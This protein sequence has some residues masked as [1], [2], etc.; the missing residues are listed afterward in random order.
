MSSKT[1]QC[2]WIV[3]TPIL[4]GSARADQE[5]SALCSGAFRCMEGIAFAVAGAV[6]VVAPLGFTR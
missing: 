3:L 2:Q 6:R 5:L 1:Q 4:D